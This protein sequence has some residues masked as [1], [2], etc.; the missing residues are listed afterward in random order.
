MRSCESISRSKGC[1]CPLKQFS[2]EEKG[3]V[4]KKTGG[5]YKW[6]Y[7]FENPL[8]QPY[9]LMKGLDAGLITDDQLSLRKQQSASKYPLLF[10]K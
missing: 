10:K 3:G 5:E 4:L 2:S 1:V 7:Q 8:L 9:V 6:R